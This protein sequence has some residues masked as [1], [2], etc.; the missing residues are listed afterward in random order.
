MSRPQANGSRPEQAKGK[1]L[2]VGGAS[3]LQALETLFAHLREIV[4]RHMVHFKVGTCICPACRLFHYLLAHKQIL[5]YSQVQKIYVDTFLNRIRRISYCGTWYLDLAYSVYLILLRQALACRQG[6]GR[7]DSYSGLLACE[8]LC[9]PIC[10]RLHPSAID[11]FTST[12]ALQRL[13]VL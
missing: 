1:T 3:L 11:L 12:T 4:S 2:A 10:I 8:K 7:N 6:E 9:L 5:W 13:Y